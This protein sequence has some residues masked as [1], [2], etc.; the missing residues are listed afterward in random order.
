MCLISVLVQASEV[1]ALVNE[2]TRTISIPTPSSVLALFLPVR[3]LQDPQL[4]PGVTP[5]DPGAPA[6]R[7]RAPADA[8]SGTSSCRRASR[9]GPRGGRRDLLAPA[10][11]GMPQYMTLQCTAIPSACAAGVFFFL[12]LFFFGKE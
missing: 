11:Q 9:R 7:R 12:F 4:G 8:A 2:V 3:G 5:R 10:A 6:V 1:A